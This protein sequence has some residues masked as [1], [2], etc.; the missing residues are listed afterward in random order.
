MTSR[1]DESCNSFGLRLR[2]TADA[3]D[4]TIG[5][6]VEIL[7]TATTS[8]SSLFKGIVGT[9][10]YAIRPAVPVAVCFWHTATA[11]PRTSLGCII[12]A[13]VNAIREGVTIGITFTLVAT[14]IL[15]SKLVRV[16][17]T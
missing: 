17:R 4:E 16:V 11:E 9:T 6:C 1:R 8:P 10:V 15:G 14:A 7:C 5:V 2:T 13:S 12:G 3:I